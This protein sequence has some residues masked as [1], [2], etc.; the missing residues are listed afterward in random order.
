[1]SDL[2]VNR[3]TPPRH[4]K[5]YRQLDQGWFQCVLCGDRLWPEKLTGKYDGKTYCNAHLEALLANPPECGDVSE[6][7][8]GSE[9]TPTVRVG[10]L[11]GECKYASTIYGAGLVG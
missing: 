9:A 11:Y 2:G 6:D 8:R 3:F 10:P 1:M 5:G 7:R 4:E